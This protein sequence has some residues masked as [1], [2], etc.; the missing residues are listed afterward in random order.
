MSG[1]LYNLIMHSNPEFWSGGN[2]YIYFPKER[3][4]EC[5]EDHLKKRFQA[6]NKSTINEIKKL[7]TL[8]ATE[9]EMTDT[10]IGKIT[11][12]EEHTLPPISF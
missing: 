9:Q 11:N 2:D 10:R 8:F 4:L 7:P 5:T 3:F 6:L 1:E 12:I